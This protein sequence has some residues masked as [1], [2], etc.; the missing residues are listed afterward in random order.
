MQ[1]KPSVQKERLLSLDILRGITI[2][3][4]IIVNE[5]GIHTAVFPPLLHAEWNGITPTDFVYPSFIFII[6][7]SIVLAYSQKIALGEP[8]RKMVARIVRRS[9]LLFVIGVLLSVA[10]LFDFNNVRIPGVL[11][12]IA[13]V[14]FCCSMLFIYTPRKFQ[15]R[16]GVFILIVYWL[17]M[18]FVPV[19]GYRYPV[20]EPGKN[21]AAW[22]DALVIPGR[23]WQGTWDPEG[24]LST[25]PAIVTGLAGMMAGHLLIGNQSREQKIIWLFTA[26]FISFGLGNIW[27]W[28]FPLNKN[29][30]T[31]S[32]V[33]Y[34]AGLTSMALACLY[35][36]V[37][38][39]GHK[40]WAKFAIIFGSNAITAYI[41]ADIFSDLLF[42]NWHGEG[43]SANAAII[44]EALKTGIAPR[45]ISLLWAVC[46]CALCFVPI[47]FLYRRKIFI[48]I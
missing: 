4:M 12:R 48:K 35:F 5:P 15:W 18:R 14:F 37:D 25:F 24:I 13:I 32:F 38:V 8:R 39:K 7:V 40:R 9:I 28:F 23:M 17:V 3:F 34:T 47:Y 2:A 19:P 42:L 33:L 31:S 26:G 22:L 45:V 21:L 1:N 36:L 16:L 27:D 20:L 43:S 11:Q 41:V 46:F 44:A 29:L 6:G 30:W 10:P